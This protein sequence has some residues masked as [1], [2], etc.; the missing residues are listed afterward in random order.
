MIE[1]ILKR[2]IIFQIRI[3]KETSYQYKRSSKKSSLLISTD[4]ILFNYSRKRFALATQVLVIKIKI[5]SKGPIDKV[6][7]IL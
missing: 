2:I 7:K 5:N 4:Q 3:S 1:L 6:M